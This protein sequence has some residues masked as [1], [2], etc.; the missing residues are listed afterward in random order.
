VTD[1]PSADVAEAVA[2]A[3]DARPVGWRRVAGGRYT[4][5]ERWLVEFDDRRRAFAKI[6]ATELTAGWLRT[7]HRAYREIAAPVMPRL[8]GWSD[9][10]PPV[11]LLED[12]SD[13]R[14][15]PLW[16][17][18]L[19]ERV[20]AMLD[21]VAH[22]HCPAWAPPVDG[23]TELFSGWS[24]IAADPGPFLG[25]GLVTARWLDASLPLLVAHERPAELAGSALLHLDVRSDNLCFTA[26]RA[27]LIDWDLVSRGNPLFDVAAWLPSLAVEGGPSPEEVRPEAS[28]F[29]AALAGIWCSRAPQ[30]V[31][32][33]APDVRRAQR[34]QGATA[35]RWAARWLTLPAP[36]GPDA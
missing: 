35:L 31:I 34:E 20:L 4:A 25:L 28:V 1:E 21:V 6:G 29:S 12:L 26:D 14:W 15:P 8:M 3:A 13:A 36:D 7:E 23:M 22:A 18:T 30:P 11:L 19:V 2:R 27:L 5:A 9:G 33:D 24:T 10:A 16:D 17:A 32:T